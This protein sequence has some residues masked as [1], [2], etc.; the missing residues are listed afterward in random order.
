M[1]K[2]Q[3]Q[4]RTKNRG[5]E[6]VSINAGTNYNLLDTLQEAKDVIA[7]AREYND[8]FPTFTYEYRIAEI[9]FTVHY[10]NQ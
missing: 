8:K 3:A 9:D 4:I 10:I 2:Y 5:E 6:W 1:T 7:K